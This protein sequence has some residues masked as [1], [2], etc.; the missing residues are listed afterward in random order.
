MNVKKIA[1]IAAIALVAF[2][3]ITQP[4]SSANVVKNILGG[5]GDG[6]EAV[7]SFA[8]NLVA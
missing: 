4:T 5:L 2:F 3:L 6:A 1:I 7:V 8:K